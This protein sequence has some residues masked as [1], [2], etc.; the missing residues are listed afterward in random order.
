ME[1]KT[2]T[3]QPPSLKHYWNREINSDLENSGGRENNF[4]NL[5]KRGKH[6][7]NK[8][9]LMNSTGIFKTGNMMRKVRNVG[10]IKIMIYRF[11]REA[12]FLKDSEKVG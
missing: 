11:Y 8:S 12:Y 1:C 4:K 9:N 7:Q 2:P 3:N 10:T 6:L 5:H